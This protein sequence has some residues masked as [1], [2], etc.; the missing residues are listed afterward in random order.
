M[1]KY[2]KVWIKCWWCKGEGKGPHITG[3]N[4]RY[5][6]GAGGKWGREQ[7]M[8]CIGGPHDGK[9]KTEDDC[10]KEY[11]RYNPSFN[12]NKDKLPCIMVH[13]SVWEALR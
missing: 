13:K 5:C 2:N 9:E 8:L 7:V 10:G 1:P 6:D 12:T 4:C 11:R 3:Y